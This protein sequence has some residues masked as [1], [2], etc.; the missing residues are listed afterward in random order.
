MMHGLNRDRRDLRDL[1]DQSYVQYQASNNTLI[2]IEKPLTL[3]RDQR[4]DVALEMERN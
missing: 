4:Q 3:Y 1:Q 2:E